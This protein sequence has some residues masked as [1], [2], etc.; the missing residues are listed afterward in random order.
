MVSQRNVGSP[1][2]GALPWVGFGCSPIPESP[3]TLSFST[4]S[5]PLCHSTMTPLTRQPPCFRVR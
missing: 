5:T 2:V 3:N 1:P 4:R